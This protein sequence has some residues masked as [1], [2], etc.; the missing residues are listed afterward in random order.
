MRAASTLCSVGGSAASPCSAWAATS[1]SRNSGLPSAVSTI[2]R[3]SCD[4]SS[5]APTRRRAARPGALRAR[6]VTSRGCGTAHDGR[7]SSSSGRAMQTIR[8][9]TPLENAA[10]CSSRSRSV[11]PA[12]WTSSRTTISGRRARPPR[13]AGARPAV[14]SALTA[15][16]RARSRRASRAIGG[17]LAAAEDL[18]EPRLRVAPGSCRTISASGLK[19]L[20]R[21]RAAAPDDG[22]RRARSRRSARATRRDLPIPGVPSSVTSRTGSRVAP[23]ASGA[24]ELRAARR[25]ASPR[26]AA[27]RPRRARRP[28]SRQAG[29]PVTAQ[30]LRPDEPLGEP[31]GQLAEQD[32][33]GGRRPPAGA[34]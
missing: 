23:S 32:L 34:P 5:A 29:T 13:T 17:L 25:T 1:C 7:L 3:A 2:L 20:P 26:S 9:G 31:A 30:R 15:P 12:Q 18:H 24:A 33:A 21:R 14:S 22:G 19:E 11:G 16:E 8:I 10:T 4:S 6:A 28:S 27:G